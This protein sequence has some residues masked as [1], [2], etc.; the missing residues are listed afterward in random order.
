MSG[1]AEH[2]GVV[3]ERGP[4]EMVPHW[5][6]HER[7]VSAL[8]V[9]LYMI[10][11]QHT[12]ARATC[13]PSRQRLAMLLGVSLPTL[14]RAREQLVECGAVCVTQ[15]RAD[16]LKWLS[17]VYHV[18]WNRLVDCGWGSQETLPPL[19]KNLTD[20]SKESS[21]L[22]KTQRTKTQVQVHSPETNFDAFWETYPRKVGKR[23]AQ[24]A[25]EQAT[26]DTNPGRIL[27]GAVRYRDDPNR[28]APYT[29]HP[30][31]WLRAGRWDDDPLP[32]RAVPPTGGRNKMVGYEHIYNQLNQAKGIEQ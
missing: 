3:V 2:I 21:T 19:V 28:E 26:L 20:P 11:R 5:L 16:S 1:D 32:A 15:R 4:F 14:D 8:G 29:A 24:K 13:Y 18:H 30:A 9:R 25:W 12:D 23:D 22:T 17:N 31:T 27:D 7:T 6:L 10:L